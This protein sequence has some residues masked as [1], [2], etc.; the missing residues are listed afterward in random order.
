MDVGHRSDPS[1]G[2]LAPF[3]AVAGGTK[4]GGLHAPNDRLHHHCGRAAMSVVC[5]QQVSGLGPQA[6]LMRI[7]RG[8]DS[9]SQHF[10]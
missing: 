8:L 9:D 6:P 7:R 5:G 10:L 3:E 4:Q 1:L 2:E